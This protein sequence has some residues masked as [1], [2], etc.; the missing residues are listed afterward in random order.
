MLCVWRIQRLETIEGIS[1][2]DSSFHG[3]SFSIVS[4][5]I[6]IRHIIEEVR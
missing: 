1:N 2:S 6:E 5:E 3:L 4:I